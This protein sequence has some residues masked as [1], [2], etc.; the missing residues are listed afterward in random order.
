MNSEDE[1]KGVQS[2]IVHEKGETG[3][4]EGRD[5]KDLNENERKEKKVMEIR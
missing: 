2:Q 1:Q 3:D 5:S 4:I